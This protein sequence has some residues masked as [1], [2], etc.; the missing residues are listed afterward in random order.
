MY[1]KILKGSKEILENY[2]SFIISYEFLKNQALSSSFLAQLHQLEK[3]VFIV[4]ND[5]NYQKQ[6]YL[7]I[8]NG[9]HTGVTFNASNFYCGSYL[10]SKYATMK[11]KGVKNAYVLGPESICKELSNYDIKSCSVNEHNEKSFGFEYAMAMDEK[12]SDDM[13]AQK[14]PYDIG[15][16]F[17]LIF[18]DS[19][20]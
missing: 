2:E 12:I 10:L 9:L 6:E 11:H 20:I 3:K 14:D 8:L 17:Y 7:K 13:N 19:G 16:V 15:I 4:T 5:C 1:S 18:S